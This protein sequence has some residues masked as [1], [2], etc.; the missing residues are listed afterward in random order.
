VLKVATNNE[1]R[2]TTQNVSTDSHSRTK[3]SNVKVSVPQELQNAC[4]SALRL[5]QALTCIS[6]RLGFLPEKCTASRRLLRGTRASSIGLTTNQD[7][8]NSS[9]IFKLINPRYINN[10]NGQ[11]GRRPTPCYA[12]SCG[13]GHTNF[14]LGD[15]DHM[16]LQREVSG[17]WKHLKHKQ[18][19]FIFIQFKN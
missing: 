10:S 7:N 18:L 4:R 2:C 11:H 19:T 12:A 16:R 17:C 5:A 15:V 3:S 1:Q 13:W 6:L 9:V 14:G 8:F